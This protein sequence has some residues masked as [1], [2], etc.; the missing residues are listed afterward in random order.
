M[1]TS[2]Q[3]EDDLAAAGDCGHRGE[4]RPDGADPDARE[5]DT[6]DRDRVDGGEEQRER[7]DRDQLGRGK[8][9]ERGK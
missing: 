2:A 9:G 5:H 4:Q 6:G 1:G 3:R 7:R 8:E